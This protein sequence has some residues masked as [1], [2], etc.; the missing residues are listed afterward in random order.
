MALPEIGKLVRDLIPEIITKSGKT[1]RTS[2]LEREDHLAALRL[3][4]LEEAQELSRACTEEVP[5]EMADV[6]EV[7]L[8]I[9]HQM[10]I[11]WSSIE[12]LA[13][14]KSKERGGFRGG[15]WLLEVD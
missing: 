2:I 15:I 9:A 7:L 8:A 13:L 12:Q 6:Y 3:K 5:E 11:P 14:K 10:S 1:P 4:I